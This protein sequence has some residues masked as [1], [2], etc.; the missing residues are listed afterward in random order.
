MQSDNFP[1]VNWPYIV[2][3]ALIGTSAL[4]FIAWAITSQ[5]YGEWSQGLSISGGWNWPTVIAIDFACALMVVA[6]YWKVY[7][8]TKT[9]IDDK[10]I[11]QPS[12][13]GIRTI[14]WPDVTN[15]EVFGGVGYHIYAGKKK[16]VVTPYAY[17]DPEGV[18]ET[19]RVN[20]LAASRATA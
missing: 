15:V 4:F 6:L 7:F 9:T 14:S 12:L 1:R 13:F 20:V 2:F 11:Y 18:I 3:V 16:I 8:D 19:L 10:G 5:V 17:K